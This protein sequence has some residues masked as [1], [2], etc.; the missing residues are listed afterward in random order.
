MKVDELAGR[1]AYLD[2]KP[3][4]GVWNL[5]LPKHGQQILGIIVSKGFRSKP[6]KRGLFVF[7]GRRYVLRPEAAGSSWKPQRGHAVKSSSVRDKEVFAGPG[8][9]I[10]RLSSLEI[11]TEKW[12]VTSLEVD[13]EH[14]LLMRDVGQYS[15]LGEARSVYGFKHFYKDAYSFKPGKI[16]AEMKDS[17]KARFL[18]DSGDSTIRG[19]GEAIS[20]IALPAQGMAVDESGTITL[21]IDAREIESMAIEKVSGGALETEEGRRNIVR[22]I[23]EEYYEKRG[24]RTP[25]HEV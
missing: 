16:V 5:Y 12:V 3:F 21:P 13:V 25:P 24:A 9:R 20:R 2:G 8:W 4:G 6:V 15:K 14:Q 11:D 19:L 17:Q 7:E 10:G 22:K 18:T 1:V 23:F